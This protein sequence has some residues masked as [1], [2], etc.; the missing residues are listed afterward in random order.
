MKDILPTLRALNIDY[1][2]FMN[3][4]NDPAAHQAFIDQWEAMESGEVRSNMIQTSNAVNDYAN[5]VGTATAEQTALND[6]L[7]VTPAM[8]QESAGAFRLLR[9]NVAG[10]SPA[11]QTLIDYLATGG[12]ATQ[13]TADAMELLQEQT[14]KASDELWS[15]AQSKVDERIG[16]VTEAVD[17][18]AEA[19][20]DWRDAM[21]GAAQVMASAD[22]QT[23]GIEAAGDAVAQFLS[24]ATVNPTMVDNLEAVDG[25]F[26]SIAE[27]GILDD[28]TTSEGRQ[29]VQLLQQLGQT[30]V[31]RITQAFE[32]SGGSLVDFRAE[33]GHVGG[34]I[35]TQL[36]EQF[37]ALG[38]EFDDA[39]DAANNLMIQMGLI[40]ENVNTMY[41]LM[42]VEAAKAQLDLLAVYI[43]RIP[44]NVPVRIGAAVARG[45]FVAARIMAE[46]ALGGEMLV[47]VH[48][49]LDPFMKDVE[50]LKYNMKYAT[51]VAIPA[52]M[53]L[54][55]S[56]SIGRGTAANGGRAVPAGVELDED[57][58]PVDYT[59]AAYTP[60]APP[61]VTVGGS[62]LVNV[63][64]TVQAAVVG[65]RFDTQRMLRGAV[66]ELERL[67]QL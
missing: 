48:A 41:A 57:G 16:N 47:P 11:W 39:R 56:T 17:A 43:D 46:R 15:L 32:A 33:M 30:Y 26:A 29:Q 19:M 18:S 6:F 24:N 5:A 35:R 22:Y 63:N 9:D 60:T 51:P 2:T 59:A 34:G 44:G 67:G 50:N 10:S 25:L 14:G 23:A 1:Q 13:E 28:L 66:R 21:A 36:I 27:H 49:N 20:D 40:P 65:N 54:T 52:R 31:P 38:M 64:L 45:D 62:R 12:V 53:A 55:G 8:V 58:A 3:M 61:V 42:G 4:V 37:M 7:D